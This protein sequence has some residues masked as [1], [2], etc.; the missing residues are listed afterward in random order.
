M[1]VVRNINTT[2][3]V[4]VFSDRADAEAFLAIG[5]NRNIFVIE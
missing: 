2:R 3:L 5:N 4:A 1:I